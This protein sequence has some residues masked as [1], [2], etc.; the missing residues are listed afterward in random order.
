MIQRVKNVKGSEY[1]PY[2]LYIHTYTHTH[3]HTHTH[4]PSV[5]LH[6]PAVQCPIA[7]WARAVRGTL[8]GGDVEGS[9]VGL[10]PALVIIRY[11]VLAHIVLLQ[12]R[13]GVALLTAQRQWQG[14]H[15]CRGR[16]AGE[17]KILRRRREI[18]KKEKKND[19]QGRRGQKP[20]GK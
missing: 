1:F 5:Y 3:T 6:I 19:E 16:A 10:A 9:G 2:P 11:D 14:T 7:T 4:T 17:Q 8:E 18:G 13:Q 12:R 15:R 20:Q